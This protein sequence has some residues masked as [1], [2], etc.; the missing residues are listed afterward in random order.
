[1]MKR[2]PL[3]ALIVSGSVVLAASTSAAQLP[4]DPEGTLWY[5]EP[6]EAWVEALPIGNGRLGA[7]VFGGTDSEHLQLNE[8]TLYSG[9]PTRT[10][11]DIDV[12]ERFDEVVGL[13]RDGEHG[14]AEDLIRSDWLG[15]NMESYQ[16]LGDL[17]LDFP[18]DGEVRGYTRLLDLDSGLVRIRYTRGGV[19]HTREIFASHP[20]Q[21]TVVRL[22]VDRPGALGFSARLGSVHP[23]AVTA[24]LG[25]RTLEMT[26]QAPGFALRR[27][28]ELVERLGDQRKYPEI[29]DEQGRRRPFAKQVLYGAEAGGLGMRFAARVLVRVRAGTV[30]TDSM[31]LHVRG[32]DEAVLLLAAGTSFNGFDRS[33]ALDGTDAG[34]RAGRDL[35]AAAA[36]PYG[37]LLGRHVA[38]HR[39]LYERVSLR[40]GEPGRQ[41][42]LTTDERLRLFGNG[43]DASL[44]ALFFQFGRYLMIAGSRPGGQPLNL[45]GIWNDQVLPPWNSGYTVNINTEMN[46]WPAEVTNLAE[47]HEPLFRMVDELATNGARTAREMYGRRG[48]VA[49]HNVG[50]WRTA[51]PIDYIPRAAFW[52]M[53]PGWLVSH[54][55]EH[56]LFG[57][58]AA[59]LRERAYPLMKGAA[60]FYLDWLVEDGEGRLVTP[61]GTSPENEFLYGD[62]ARGSV[63]I[64]PTMDLAIIRELFSRTARASE[65]LSVDP[66]LRAELNAALP[67][68]SP[69][70]IGKHGQLQEWSLDF[71]EADPQHRHLSHLYGFHPGNQINARGTPALFEAVR[72]TLERR[73]DPATGWSMGW[74]INFWARMGDGDHAHRL[75]RN[76]LTLVRDS[77]TRMTGGGTYPNLFDAHPPF[78]IDGNFGATAGVAEMLVQ[79][80]AGEIDLLPALPAAWPE[81][82]VR[83]LRARGGF[84]VDLEWAERRLTRVV[85]RSTLGGVARVR[86]PGEMLVQGGEARPASGPN[87]NL[88]FQTVD[89]G[90]PVVAEGVSSPAAPAP[91]GWVVDIVTRPGD[92]IVLLRR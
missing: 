4:S 6:A 25:G 79:S 44:A 31:G 12:T 58:D 30:W 21:V 37:T 49:H 72:R 90:Q 26:G 20:D 68:L 23:T 66:A 36:K 9:D 18:R 38:D 74:K 60:E 87:P 52:P 35:A 54:L 85:L 13:L 15:R 43:D 80:H 48:W 57:G 53:S 82:S 89:P 11:R 71:E 42:R 28:L 19:A 64:G 55:W 7:M 67:R 32:A 81:G 46:Y 84:E 47:L 65:I 1:M 59:F 39:A 56:Y 92:Q 29:F 24:P 16:P 78:Q 61:V 2:L 27:E 14:A 22:A 17:W 69:Y 40:L 86:A 73:G 51:E 88:F 75:L 50:L 45:Q 10:F 83:G 5:D 77:G 91:A 3:R 8:N 62:S 63:S 34:A 76:Q 41:S 70:R 33:P